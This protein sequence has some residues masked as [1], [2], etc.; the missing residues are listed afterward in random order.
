VD[1]A[2][3]DLKARLLDVPLTDLFARARDTVPARVPDG[4]LEMD[5]R[6]GHGM[7]LRTGAERFRAA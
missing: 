2:L 1:V 4:A 3:W 6:P 7:S 5:D